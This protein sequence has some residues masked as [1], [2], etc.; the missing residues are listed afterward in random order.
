M[1]RKLKI[2]I[3][4]GSGT[5]FSGLLIQ[6][7]RKE[8]AATLVYLIVCGRRSVARRTL[9]Q[10]SVANRRRLDESSAQPIGVLR[11]MQ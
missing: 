4:A 11:G 3:D 10:S 8:P 7:I 2:S 9:G 1:A 6:K 5:T